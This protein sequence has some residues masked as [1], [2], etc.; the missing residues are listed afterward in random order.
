MYAGG[1]A[2]YVYGVLA[3]EGS[4]YSGTALPFGAFPAKFN[5]VLAELSDHVDRPVAAAVVG[6]AR[7]NLNDLVTPNTVTGD[8]RLDGCSTTLHEAATLLPWTEPADRD[9]GVAVVP[10]CPIDSDTHFVL[11]AYEALVAHDASDRQVAEF[12]SRTEDG[13]LSGWD[14]SKLRV[15]VATALLREGDRRG[16]RQHLDGLAH[17]AIFSEWAARELEDTA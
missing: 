8:R 1:L 15:L 10:L 16:T 4:E 5:R 2:E 9:E 17:D 13:T 7:L 14:R 11:A 6:A 12:E 3:K